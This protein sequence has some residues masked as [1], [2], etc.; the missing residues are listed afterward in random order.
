MIY[1]KD[2]AMKKLTAALLA[3]TATAV[4]ANAALALDLTCA[5]PPP[6]MDPHAVV[7]LRITGQEYANTISNLHPVFTLQNGETRDR[8][9]QYQK[10]WRVESVNSSSGPA[11]MWRDTMDPATTT[12]SPSSSRMIQMKPIARIITPTRECLTTKTRSVAGRPERSPQSLTTLQ[13]PTRTAR[14]AKL[15]SP[16]LPEQS[17]RR[18]TR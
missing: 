12:L 13:S 16:A 3:A 6:D 11:I 1:E 10:G 15:I 7:A 5:V 17:R 14:I 18:H 4:S 8:S 9:V 2:R